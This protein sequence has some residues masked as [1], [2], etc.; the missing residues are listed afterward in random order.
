MSAGV[1]VSRKDGEMK[2]FL[3]SKIAAILVLLVLPNVTSSQETKTPRELSLIEGAKKEGKLVYWGAGNA[4]EVESFLAKFRQRYPFI[5]TEWWRAAAGALHQKTLSE[6]RAG[7]HNV[8]VSV[9]DMEYLQELK[10][11][12]LMKRYEW[13]N[14]KGWSHAHKDPEGYWVYRNI[15][16][17]M[18]GYNTTLVSAAD[19]PK[20]WE[21]VLDPK[22][23][24]AISMTKDG[25]EWSLQLWAA[26]GKEKMISYLKRLSQ[27][28]LVLGE[29]GTA[30]IEMLAA[31]ASKIDMELNLNR[32]MDYQEKGAPLEWVR[33]NPVLAIGN[34]FFI[35]EH[36]PH[37][38]A[39]MLFADWF[40]SLEGGQ[41]YYDVSGKLL[42]H[43]GI[44]GRISEALKGLNVV[45][46]PAKIAVHGNEANK[47]FK[48]IFWK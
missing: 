18:I 6:A 13:H 20:T 36:A 26:W 29:G 17:T 44:K 27:N 11:T 23:K 39:A 16:P 10:K 40:T 42:P 30:R 22:W 1:S 14:T 7:A 28:N 43:P 38:N 24:G 8:D 2:N 35:A 3:R 31:G 41:A 46:T 15:I 12:G 4:K 47:I 9:T 5:K 45:Y 48:D 21:H 37:P 34:P 32:I 25:G 19:A 33:T